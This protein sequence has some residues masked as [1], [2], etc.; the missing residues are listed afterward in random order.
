MSNAD[1]FRAA[2]VKGVIG[3]RSLKQLE[4]NFM[5]VR[6]GSIFGI[7][8]ITIN[9][10]VV[11]DIA[12]YITLYVNYGLNIGFFVDDRKSHIIFVSK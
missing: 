10:V 8:D 6:N 1:F 11:T 9:S 5:I 12:L 2:G 4:N 3:E 7:L